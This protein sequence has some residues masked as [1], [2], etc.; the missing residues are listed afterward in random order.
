MFKNILVAIDLN[1]SSS[2]EKAV[3][4][5][6]QL[7]QST[8]A[9]LTLL[10]VVPDFG[11]SI[12]SQ[13]F[14]EGFAESALADTRTKL[15]AFASEHVP[16]DIEQTLIVSQGTIYEEI[17]RASG[18]VSADLIVVAAHRPSLKDYLLGPN[19]SRVVRHSKR[20][21]LVIRD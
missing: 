21:V 8:G 15:S 18:E 14:P 13:Y 19:A 1:E 2:W 16:G 3:P 6:V 17:I 12:V 11:M 4:T 5:A 7:C 10:T 20:S 9:R